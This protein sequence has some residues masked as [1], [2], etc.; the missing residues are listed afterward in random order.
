MA[1]TYRCRPSE[2]VGTAD[3]YAAYCLDEACAY[4]LGALEEG[5]RPFFGEEGNAATVEML[6]Q[7]GVE[8]RRA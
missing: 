2:M 8:V 4:I 7:W 5:K 3:D 6:R 1:Q